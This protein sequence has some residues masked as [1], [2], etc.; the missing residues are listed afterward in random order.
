MAATSATKNR[1]RRLAALLGGVGVGMVVLAFASVPLY[2]VFCQITGYA[3][4]P[5]IESA[6]P[7]AVGPATERRLTVRFDA[8][9]NSRLAWR[10]RPAQKAMEVRPGEPQLAAYVAENLS[11]GPL[12]G[13]A[14]FNVTPMKAAAY[15]AKTECF[16][17][18]EQRLAAG[19]SADM[20]VQFYVDPEIWTDPETREVE[21]ITL[22]Y[23]FFKAR[24]DG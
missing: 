14:T 22:S 12:T 20:P 8:S 5:R 1:N 10:F 7:V 17:F 23:T 2:R 13:T 24:E 11:G 4:T 18:T 6:R 19:E 3:G 15:F 9:V 21:T 16:C